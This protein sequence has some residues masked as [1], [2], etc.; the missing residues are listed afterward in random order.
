MLNFE[1]ERRNSRAGR[2][3]REKNKQNRSAI[4][5]VSFLVFGAHTKHGLLVAT[6]METKKWQN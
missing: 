6:S 5:E 2:A 4:I 3:R 1:G